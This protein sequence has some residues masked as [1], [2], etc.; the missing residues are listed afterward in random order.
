[1]VFRYRDEVFEFPTQ[2]VFWLAKF[3]GYFYDAP[4]EKL[5]ELAT[6]K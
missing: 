5:R 6:K 1:M 4:V 3:N 2:D